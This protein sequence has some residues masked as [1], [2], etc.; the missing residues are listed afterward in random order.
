MP[1]QQGQA[2]EMTG[3]GS[4]GKPQGG[5]PP[6]PPPLEIAARF[7]HSHRL[8][9]ERLCFLKNPK[10]GAPGTHQPDS[11]L[12]A[13]PWIGKCFWPLRLPARSEQPTHLG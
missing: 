2:V 5:F 8:D 1:K 3:R 4:R 13:H 7:P 12:Q 11:F 9:D 6:L 10:K